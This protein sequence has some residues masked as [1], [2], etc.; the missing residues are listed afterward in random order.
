MTEP[1]KDSPEV[2]QFITLF[3][4]L[5]HRSDDAPEELAELAAAM[6]ACSDCALV[7]NR[8]SSRIAVESISAG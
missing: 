2:V 3:A 4:R 5:K 7:A 8:A 6:H 1:G